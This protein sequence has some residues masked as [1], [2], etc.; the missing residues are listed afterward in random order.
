MHRNRNTDSSKEVLSEHS[1][2]VFSHRI[3]DDD[4]PTIGKGPHRVANISGND[5]HQTCP[6]RLRLAIVGYLEFTFDL[7]IH[8]FLRVEMLMYDRTPLNS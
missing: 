8:L 1:A 4:G 6:R 5:R 2:E 3:V 7:L